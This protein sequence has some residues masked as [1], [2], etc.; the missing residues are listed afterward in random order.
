MYAGVAADEHRAVLTRTDTLRAFA[1]A[2]AQTGQHLDG[3]EV[4]SALVTG[5]LVV[6]AVGLAGGEGL[7]EVLAG[8][9]GVGDGG[10]RGRWHG[11]VGGEGAGAHAGTRT[12]ALG[13]S[14]ALRKR[15]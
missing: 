7:V 2:I 11:G 14:L 12:H 10:F 5:H 13:L 6:D 3:L 4:G 9:G 8:K 1:V 15:G